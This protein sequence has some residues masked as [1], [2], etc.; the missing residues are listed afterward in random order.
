MSFGG[1]GPYHTLAGERPG[2][3]R[4]TWHGQ[5]NRLASGD[6]PEP[7]LIKPEADVGYR[8][9]LNRRSGVDRWTASDRNHDYDPSS[10]FLY[11][12]GD[13]DAGPV[14]RAFFGARLPVIRQR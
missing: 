14:L 2:A 5:A 8:R 11:G 9:N 4:G 1:S 3:G 12:G 7:V 13:Q 6:D 10:R